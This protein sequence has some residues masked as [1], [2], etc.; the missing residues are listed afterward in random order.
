ML[1]SF[2]GND[3]Q[4]LF[5]VPIKYMVSSRPYF[6]EETLDFVINFKGGGR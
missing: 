1:P 6:M 2:D 3:L 5:V 4:D